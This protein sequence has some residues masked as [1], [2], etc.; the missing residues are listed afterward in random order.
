[1]FLGTTGMV[2]F[3]YCFLARTLSLLP[4]NR[5]VPLSM[6]MLQRTYFA[7][8]C[9]GNVQQGLPMEAAPVGEAGGLA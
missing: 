9:A 3:G 4:W 5:S 8:P 1:M 6:A 7:P 2:L